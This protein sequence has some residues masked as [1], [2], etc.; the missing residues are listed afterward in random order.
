MKGNMRR[1]IGSIVFAVIFAGVG[2]FAYTN[3][4]VYLLFY[5]IPLSAPVFGVIA[6][7]LFGLAIFQLVTAGKK[8]EV[9]TQEF[10]NQ[11]ASA[12]QAAVQ[13]AG[14]TEATPLAT[15]CTINVTHVKGGLGALNHFNVMLNG[16]VAG[17][18]KSKKSLSFTTG[19]AENSLSIQ[20]SQSGEVVNHAFRAVSGGVVNLSITINM[21]GATSISQ[22]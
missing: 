19:V 8:D 6:V 7:L 9:A 21:L 17:T 12:Q 16:Y 14:A 4:Y 18:I 1:A 10:Q 5:V 20:H 3:D 13:D 15:P 22:S 2:I 11:A